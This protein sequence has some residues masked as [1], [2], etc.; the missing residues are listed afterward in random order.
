[1]ATPGFSLPEV[2]GTI[3]NHR[4]LIAGVTMITAVAGAIF[5][6]VGP[7]YYEAK[8][9]FL[10][11]NPMYADRS[12]LYNAETKLFDYF[13]NEDDVNRAILMAES[14]IVQDEVIRNMHLPEAYKIDIST[15]KGN[16]QMH[17]RF[18]KNFN[19]IRTEY[20]DLVLSFSDTDPERAATVANECVRILE[21]KFG[22]YYKNMR[23]DMYQTIALK[24]KEE[25][26]SINALTDT[27]SALRRFYGIYDIISPARNNIM[28]S[29]MKENGHKDYGR[30]VEEIQ[31]VESMKDELV[32]DRAKQTT[33]VNQY[34]T[35]ID[36][37]TLPM[38]N[39][40]TPA[41]NP[42][43]PKGL[44]GML[45]VILSAL[46]G[47]FFSTLVLSMN[48]NYYQRSMKS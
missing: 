5:Y 30:G 7:R 13:A 18:E 22:G 37:N 17:R 45:T 38:T 1:M 29:A 48:D 34:K 28:L 11:R 23:K 9:E 43:S 3:R 15:P 24:I 8:T 2:F 10:L 46:L 26:S 39:V 25:D 42:V 47:F 40:V 12:N 19:I 20:K 35:A 4:R 44:G 31:N 27:L 41:R 14:D 36:Q 6:L 16:M 33:L 32:F 21:D